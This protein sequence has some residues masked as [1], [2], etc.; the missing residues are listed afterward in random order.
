MKYEITCSSSPVVTCTLAENEKFVTESGIS[1]FGSPNI[2]VHTSGDVRFSRR[3]VKKVATKKY[4]GALYIS[5]ARIGKILSRLLSG[6]A[7]FHNIY[8]SHK[9]EGTVSFSSNCIAGTVIALSV[10][11]DKGYIL[12]KGCF[13][14]SEK[15]VR[16]SN[17]KMNLKE[18]LLGE[19][20]FLQKLSG[21]GISF[22]EAEGTVEKHILKENEHLIAD[23]GLLLAM[24]DSCTIHTKRRNTL[25]SAL[26]G[27][28]RL[29]STDIAGPG[30]VYLNV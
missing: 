8:V 29:Y 21:S 17:Y 2:K 28:K 24:S 7:L 1:A 23:V 16:L 14:A 30:T 9:G 18:G 6:G 12:N 27:G 26:F 25:K 20:I 15:G 5:L 19:G 11:K 22:I 13:L 4:F 3:F 10:S